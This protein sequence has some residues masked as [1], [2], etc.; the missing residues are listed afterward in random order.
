MALVVGTNSYIDATA[1]DAY[2][3]D[4]LRATDWSGATAGDKDIALVM[5]ATVI[6]GQEFVGAITSTTQAMA[7]PRACVADAECRAI[8]DTTVPQAITDAQAEMA[9]ALLR[10]DLTL[11]AKNKG[12]RRIRESVAGA[13]EVDKTYFPRCGAGS[14]AS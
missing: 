1:G 3:A 6:D 7:W 5:A 8:T 4:R 13:I 9:M 10:A 14:R 11:D 12:V 2:F